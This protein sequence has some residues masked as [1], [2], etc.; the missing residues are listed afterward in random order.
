MDT[1][2]LDAEVRSRIM[3]LLNNAST[4]G[5]AS[6]GA[7]TDKCASASGSCS[8]GVVNDDVSVGAIDTEEGLVSSSSSSVTVSAQ[9]QASQTTVSTAPSHNMHSALGSLPADDGDQI[10]SEIDKFRTRQAVRDKEV[11]IIMT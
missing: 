6:G 4:P 11:S 2:A 5:P 10:L 8:E 3:Q 7:S 1:I 9:H